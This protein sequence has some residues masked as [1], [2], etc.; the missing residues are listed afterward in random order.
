M[1]YTWAKRAVQR[2]AVRVGPAGARV[3]S[4]SPGVV[5]IPQGRQEAEPHPSTAGYGRAWRHA[6]G[7]GT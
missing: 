5:A 4:V 1:A 6:G 2:E 3:C 7:T